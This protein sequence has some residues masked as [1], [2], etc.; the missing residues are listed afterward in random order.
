MGV[1]GVGEA[2]RTI[3][4]VRQGS[5]E[6]CAVVCVGGGGGVA[7]CSSRR[8]RGRCGMRCTRRPGLHPALHPDRASPGVAPTSPRAQPLGPVRRE[9]R[10]APPPAS[11]VADR[12][13]RRA[14]RPELRV[15]SF[16]CGLRPPPR[17]LH[18]ARLLAGA[19]RAP[20]PA[21]P[22]APP[23]GPCGGGVQ[24]PA[25]ADT[26]SHWPLGAVCQSPVKGATTARELLGGRE[27]KIFL[28]G[29]GGI[30]GALVGT[31][32]SGGCGLA[33]GRLTGDR[34]RRLF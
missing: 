20:P 32:G 18:A 10:R 21:R 15:T 16:P 5:P 6:G 19:A 9:G 4:L 1:L 28:W 24:P 33:G 7:A 11:G 25:G 14:A 17:P 3:S 26:A 27:E 31:P 34:V 8:G 30:W 22:R 12:V 13:P 23:P 2:E 29:E